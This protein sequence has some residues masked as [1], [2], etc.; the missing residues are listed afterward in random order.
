MSFD[1]IIQLSIFVTNIENI[2]RQIPIIP[3]LRE[4]TASRCS[5]ITKVYGLQFNASRSAHGETVTN[6][7]FFESSHVPMI[8]CRLFFKENYLY[9]P[10]FVTENIPLQLVMLT[11]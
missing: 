6:Y 4:N 5:R 2:F 11:H 1:E 9:H 7:L 3:R 10:L 8:L